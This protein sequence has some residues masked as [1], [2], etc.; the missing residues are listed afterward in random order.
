MFWSPWRLVYTTCLGHR[1]LRGAGRI[2]RVVSRVPHTEHNAPCGRF[3]TGSK[4]VK[5]N[6]LLLQTGQLNFIA[7]MMPPDRWLKKH[8]TP[9]SFQQNERQLNIFKYYLSG[10]KKLCV[11]D[12]KRCIE[13]AVTAAYGI[14]KSSKYFWP[15]TTTSVPWT[16]QIVWLGRVSFWTVFSVTHDRTK[17]LVGL[18]AGWLAP[19]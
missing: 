13:P 2:E 8:L 5:K 12:M 6:R 19:K 14:Q 9:F 11:K 7:V 10:N 18:L 15:D 16:T 3:C 1:L 4:E 17:S